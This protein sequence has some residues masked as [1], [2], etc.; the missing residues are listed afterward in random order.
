MLTNGSSQPRCDSRLARRRKLS[1]ILGAS[2][3]GWAMEAVARFAFRT[4]NREGVSLLGAG[5]VA[6]GRLNLDGF[7]RGFSRELA[8]RE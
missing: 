2:E 1:F 6:R 8:M 7:S 5:D 4:A 3:P